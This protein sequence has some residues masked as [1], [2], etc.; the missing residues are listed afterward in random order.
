M[1]KHNCLGDANGGRESKELPCMQI[2]QSG[3][4]FLGVQFDERDPRIL[5]S[6]ARTVGERLY[7]ALEGEWEAHSM[8]FIQ[9]RLQYIY[10]EVERANPSLDTRVLLPN[11]GKGLPGNICGAPLDCDFVLLPTSREESIAAA[12]LLMEAS[13]RLRSLL[14]PSADSASMSLLEASRSNAMA[15]DTSAGFATFEN[16][17]MG[18]TFDRLHLGHKLLLSVAALS[19]RSRLVC[20]VTHSELLAAKDLSE[21][22]EPHAFRTAV[23]EEWLR[24]VKPSLTY[25]LPPINDPYGPSVVDPNLQAIIVSEE[26]A[27]GGQAC[28]DKR[29][30]NGLG[31]IVV[32]PIALVDSAEAIDPG[33]KDEKLSS[34][35]LR[36]SEL[37]CF[38]SSAG[39][40]MVPDEWTRRT[41][42]R[43]PTGASTGTTSTELPYV[44]GVTGG[45][46]SGKST[47][48]GMLAEIAAADTGGIGPVHVIDCDKLGHGAYIKGTA[49]FDDMVS[50]CTVA[51]CMMA[52]QCIVCRSSMVYDGCT[53]YRVSQWHGV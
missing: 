13:D 22:L 9:H 4:L 40:A 12:Q 37:G 17:C 1:E 51:W 3:L 30:T 24:S 42:T 25:D 39:R 10:E 14:I 47:A 23:V 5:L 31:P 8:R 2:G 49:C 44:L 48:S 45:I 29:E 33:A 15:A 7:I 28:S 20:G 32:V 34:S 18:G 36:H 52:V 35:D 26:T 43:A 27:A 6:A 50:G 41:M 38:R 46:A 11:E 53:V 19:T 21:F 16:C